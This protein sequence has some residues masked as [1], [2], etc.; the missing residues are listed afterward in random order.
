MAA[1]K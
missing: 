1:A